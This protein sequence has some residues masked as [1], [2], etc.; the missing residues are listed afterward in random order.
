MLMHPLYLADDL[1]FGGRGTSGCKWSLHAAA[2]CHTLMDK[3]YRW[4]LARTLVVQDLLP[5]K[6]TTGRTGLVC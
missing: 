3:L 4:S 6:D 2:R 1:P 5:G